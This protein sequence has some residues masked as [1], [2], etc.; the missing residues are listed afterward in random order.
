MFT[1]QYQR[2]S[3]GLVVINGYLQYETFR[4]VQWNITMERC[5]ES[6][7]AARQM[8]YDQELWDDGEL[9]EVM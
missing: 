1:Y 5:G 9:E 3:R 2:H 4:F 6:L 8:K 7:Q